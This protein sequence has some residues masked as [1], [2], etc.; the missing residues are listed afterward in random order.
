MSHFAALGIIHVCRK[1]NIE[2]QTVGDAGSQAAGHAQAEH[3][4]EQEFK[5]GIRCVHIF[6]KPEVLGAQFLERL[7]IT[8]T[9]CK[10]NN[11]FDM[12]QPREKQQTTWGKRM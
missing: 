3:E 10:V 7:L 11:N 12:L 8:K 2:G 4:R 5:K 1:W 6:L 9:R